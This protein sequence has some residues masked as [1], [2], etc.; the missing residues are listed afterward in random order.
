[1]GSATRQQV[2]AQRALLVLAASPALPLGLQPPSSGSISTRAVSPKPIPRFS[3]MLLLAREAPLTRPGQRDPPLN[4]SPA[5]TVGELITATPPPGSPLPLPAPQHAE[6]RPAREC[7]A[8][9]RNQI[10]FKKKKKKKEEGEEESFPK[11]IYIQC[12]LMCCCLRLQKEVRKVP[13]GGEK[14]FIKSVGG[15]D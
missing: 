15:A 13:G 6:P 3:A 7:T 10:E 12:V 1:M 2:R 9:N 4:R 5:L 8:Y 14:E 11:Y